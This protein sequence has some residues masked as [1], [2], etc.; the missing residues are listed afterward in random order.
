MMQFNTHEV[1]KQL[2]ETGMKDKTAEKLVEVIN[3]SRMT[4]FENLVT[5]QDLKIEVSGVK[6]EL[7]KEISDIKSE[8]ADVKADVARLDGKV[9]KLQWMVTFTIGL[10]VV[11]L[12][13][14]LKL[15]FSH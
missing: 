8:V 2:V 14:V 13:V 15:A 4:D 9:D 6:E 12:G 11:V 7:R 3:Q 1:F 5:K 10:L